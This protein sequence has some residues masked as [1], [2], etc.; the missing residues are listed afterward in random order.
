MAETLDDYPALQMEDD[1]FLLSLKMDF[2]DSREELFGIEEG[3]SFAQ[4]IDKLI[5]ENADV[6]DKG[7]QLPLYVP[8]L[9]D[10]GKMVGSRAVPVWSGI[11]IGF[12]LYP[13]LAKDAVEAF[14]YGNPRRI[15]HLGLEFMK[16]T[17]AFKL[18]ILVHFAIDNVLV[19]ELGIEAFLLGAY[20][21][22]FPSD[23]HYKAT[24]LPE[25]SLSTVVSSAGLHAKR[26]R[27]SSGD[28]CV[29]FGVAKTDGWTVRIRGA[30]PKEKVLRDCWQEMRRRNDS[31]RR[32]LFTIGGREYTAVAPGPDG[33]KRE[34]AGSAAV[35]YMVAWIDA[36]RA[37]EGLP[38]RGTRVDWVGIHCR[39]ECE[40]PDYINSWTADTMRRTYKRRKTK[41]P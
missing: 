1:G 8:I 40:N 31:A 10:E 19:H 17:P 30:R 23:N 34:R 37:K 29:A 24:G 39:F 9:S 14:L 6:V 38:T 22:A 27:M 28:L 7:S 35:D 12:P 16:C 20:G 13:G 26:S 32:P 36:L 18:A 2:A 33:R 41:T 15:G 4:I 5:D 21:E 11:H 3:L 25:T